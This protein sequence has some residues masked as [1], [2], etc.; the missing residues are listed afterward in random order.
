MKT[1]K[2]SKINSKVFI[3]SLFIFSS[4][5]SLSFAK[6]FSEVVS[7]VLT[8]ILKPVGSIIVSLAVL[9]FVWGVIK[10]IKSDGK[11]KE[12]GRQV[13]FWG[14]VGLF[15]MICVWG[16]VGVVKNTLSL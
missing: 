11:D 3:F 7:Y 8:S 16:I 1:T 5:F 9:Y 15:V 13:M 2:L 10:F 4:I 6:T 12:E 14:I